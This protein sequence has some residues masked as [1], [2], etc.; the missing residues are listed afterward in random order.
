MTIPRP[1]NLSDIIQTFPTLRVSPVP[2]AIY[3]TNLDEMEKKRKE[4]TI[5]VK[6]LTYDKYN[7]NT[8]F[9]FHETKGGRS[10]E[11]LQ[12]EREE[13]LSSELAFN[14]KYVSPLPTTT[15]DDASI[16][17]KLNTATILRENHLI[18]KLQSR[19]NELLA[20]YE[21][22]LRDGTEFTAWQRQMREQD[23]LLQLYYVD[24]RR[25]MAKVSN[26]E[27]K[28][29]FIKRQEDNKLMVIK[30]K[31]ETEAVLRAKEEEN[32][33]EQDELKRIA[34][35]RSQE[36]EAK[37]KLAKERL[38]KEKLEQSAILKSETAK[39]RRRK[40]VTERFEEEQRAL[41]VKELRELLSQPRPTLTPF[42]PTTAAT[43]VDVLDKMSYAELQALLESERKRLKDQEEAKRDEI[44]T[45][46]ETKSKQI[47]ELSDNIIKVREKRALFN[48]LKSQQQRATKANFQL[49][50]DKQRELAALKFNDERQNKLLAAEVERKRIQEEE[51]RVREKQ[52]SM[53]LQYGHLESY[54]ESELLKAIERQAKQKLESFVDNITR[55]EQGKNYDRLNREVVKDQT[56]ALRSKSIRGREAAVEAERQRSQAKTQQISAYKRTLAQT[57]HTQEEEAKERAKTLNP[58]ATAISATIRDEGTLRRQK[59]GL[60]LTAPTHSLHSKRISSPPLDNTT[61]TTGTLPTSARSPRPV[62]ARIPSDLDTPKP[63]SATNNTTAR[64]ITT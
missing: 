56:E 54:R 12:K 22:E 53:G 33:R 17:I 31:A 49:T 34:L 4:E 2:E 59:L 10:L 23:D 14:T 7:D 42:D 51:A 62:S 3:A 15:Y 50:L 1:P 26:E 39:L 30:Y 19:E 61:T 28:A 41:K 9:Q 27:A 5:R 40:E 29:A 46:K 45:Y 36:N 47:Q 44:L 38:I 21:V 64:V 63:S 32:K 20:A 37:L 25:E 8:T 18:N 48:R 43:G 24:C 57:M 6:Q 16:P 13:Q 35:E 60:H 11:E 55:Y 58:Y 52:R